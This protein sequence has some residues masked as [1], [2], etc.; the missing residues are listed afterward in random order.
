MIPYGFELLSE[1]LMDKIITSCGFS[2][3]EKIS[4]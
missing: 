2:D 4:L 1:Q 3:C